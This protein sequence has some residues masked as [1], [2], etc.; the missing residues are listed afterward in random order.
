MDALGL[1]PKNDNNE[2]SLN[3]VKSITS[4]STV[5]VTPWTY[6]IY[7]KVS[8]TRFNGGTVVFTNMSIKY[9]G[10]STSTFNCNIGLFIKYDDSTYH[11]IFRSPDSVIIG[12]SNT[13]TLSAGNFHF[14]IPFSTSFTVG[15][16][17][18]DGSGSNSSKTNI[19]L[20][21]SIAFYEFISV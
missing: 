3:L 6:T 1:Q 5:S 17:T 20:S 15:V 9:T 11:E 8:S 7:T 10:T 14:L 16:F 21:G 13:G 12:G 4:F 19:T 18:T 2:L